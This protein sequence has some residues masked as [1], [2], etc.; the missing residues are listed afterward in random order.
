[1][2][3]R[4]R[5]RSIWAAWR[6]TGPAGEEEAAR[7]SRIPRKSRPDHGRHRGADR[8]WQRELGLL[9]TVPAFGD[10]VARAWLAEIGPAPH[11]HFASHGK[12]ASWVSL[13]PGN[14]ISARKRKHGR[15]GDAGTYIKPVLV[16]AA[17]NAIRTRGRLQAR[18]NRLVRRFGG[19]SNPGAKKKDWDCPCVAAP[20]DENGGAHV[21]RRRRFGLAV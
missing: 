9:K 7:G 3:V 8:R 12:L 18:Y 2:L 4:T 20:L 15:T 10:V 16:Q 19:Q 14:N 6:R 21:A 13:C 17:W 1:M 11:L 5:C